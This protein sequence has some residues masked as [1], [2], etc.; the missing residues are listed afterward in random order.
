MVSLKKVMEVLDAQVVVGAK[1]LELEVKLP[2][3]AI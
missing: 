3:A 2:A 1:E